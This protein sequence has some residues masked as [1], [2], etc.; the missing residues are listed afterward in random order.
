MSPLLHPGDLLTLHYILADYFHVANPAVDV[1][2]A[3]VEGLQQEFD[4][5]RVRLRRC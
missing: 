1:N 3:G 5:D 4:H 2:F